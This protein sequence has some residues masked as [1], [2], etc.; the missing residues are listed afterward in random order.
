MFIGLA[1]YQEQLNNDFQFR[2]Y[3]DNRTQLKLLV[4]ILAISKR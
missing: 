3:L 1:I 2:E 4:L